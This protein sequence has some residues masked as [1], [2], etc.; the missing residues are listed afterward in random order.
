MP[1][2]APGMDGTAI[3]TA[4]LLFVCAYLVLRV[5]TLRRRN[6]G[7]RHRLHAADAR[8]GEARSNAG[9]GAARGAG[10]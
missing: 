2:L 10:C 5:N 8:Y 9:R 1:D 7:L 4:V 3:S 6:R